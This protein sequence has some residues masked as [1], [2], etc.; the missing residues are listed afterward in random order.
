MAKVAGPLGW[1]WAGGDSLRKQLL[2][3]AI[4]KDLLG[5]DLSPLAIFLGGQTWLF[6]ALGVATLVL[7]LGAPVALFSRPAARIW[8]VAL[9]LFHWGIFFA[10]GLTFRYPLTGLAFASF[11]VRDPRVIAMFTRICPRSAGGKE[12]RFP[13]F[14]HPESVT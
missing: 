3:D 4:R 2:V 12:K 8:V 7:E 9:L 10:M 5:G 14:D 6:L 1:S 13:T 11:V